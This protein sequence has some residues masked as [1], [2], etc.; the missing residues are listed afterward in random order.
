MDSSRVTLRKV[1]ES[2]GIHHST[3]SRALKNNPRIPAETRQRIQQAAKVMGYQPDPALSA[4]MVYRQNRATPQYHAT[5]GWMTNETTRDGWQRHEMMAYYR[6]ATRR[7]T[8]LGYNLEHFWLG[9]PCLTQQR[10]IQILQARNIRGLL[11]L[12][13]RRSRAHLL[14]DWSRFTAIS[15]GRTLAQPVFHNVHNNHYCS[16]SLLMRELKRLGYKRPGFAIWPRTNEA[17]DRSWMATFHAFQQLPPQNQIPVFSKQPW[18]PAEFRRWFAQ[19]TPDVVISHDETVLQWLES[20]GMRVPD[21]VGFALSARHGEAPARCSGVDENNEMVAEVA[22]NVLVDML[23]RGE[24][25]VPT[26][27]ISTL[28][29]GRWVAGQTLR[30]QRG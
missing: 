5:L 30:R 23:H 29:H 14:L 21:E 3:V 13:Q 8:E 26:T 6:G 25:G 15:F 2:L 24:I 18:K 11:F 10:A 16:G 20:W 7:A 27:P 1:A 19:H 22:I 28:V 9:E 4:L 17:V 12:P